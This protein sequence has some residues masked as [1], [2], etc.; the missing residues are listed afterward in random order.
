MPKTN[1]TVLFGRNAL[2]MR[3]DF[4]LTVVAGGEQPLTDADDL[5]NENTQKNYATY[6]PDYWVLDGS[7][8]FLTASANI[9]YIS[10]SQSGSDSN[11]GTDPKLKFVFNNVYSTT[12][13]VLRFA[14]GSNDYTDDITIDFYN[15]S[16]VLILSYIY[17][18][19]SWEFPT[20]QAEA[21]FKR[22]DITF[23]SSNKP[24]R[25]ARLFGIDFDTTVRW[26]GGNIKN[27][28]LTEQINPLSLELPSNEIEFT[29]F[30]DD[31]DFSITNP[32]N[33][34]AVLQENEPIEAYEQVGDVDILLGRFYLSDWESLN[35]HEARFTAKDA[36]W[37]L[38]SITYLGTWLDIASDSVTYLSDLITDGGFEHIID[39]Y[40]NGFA[41]TG[42]VPA[43]FRRNALLDAC[44]ALS[45]V[46]AFNDSVRATVSCSRSRTINISAL[47]MADALTSYDYT[48]TNSDMGN[49]KLT[50]LPV[51]T[52]AEV[53]GF[54]WRSSSD[55]TNDFTVLNEEIDAGT[56][57]IIVKDPPMYNYTVDS[58][59]AT[60][61]DSDANH[62]NLQV[63]TT[64][65]IVVT[66]RKRIMTY[67][68]VGE[69]ATGLGANVKANIVSVGQ[70]GLVGANV[71]ISEA[72]FL[73]R[74][75]QQR[76]KFTCKLY[77]STAHVGDSVLINV[78]GGQLKGYI[79]KATVNLTGGFVSDVEIIGVL[80]EV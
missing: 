21:N 13:L 75:Y 11:F 51:V 47:L 6:E 18:P 29:L 10:T 23:K 4:V 8:K 33:E 53:P 67:D 62:I 70:V 1:L 56:Y 38:G 48:L 15:A 27:G 2:T 40:W 32:A 28:T 54:H 50:L 12:G 59:D 16:D 77:A 46:S 72:K 60:I 69:D 7:Y 17:N 39:T 57:L 34:Y 36:I 25:Y 66:G 63:N 14:Q 31:P 37:M 80:V 65:T 79:E 20:N 71:A 76:Y 68:V 42:W 41:Y 58:G 45:S 35:E 49:P 61:L 78:Q 43:S 24:Y 19:D 30:S 55:S 5:N 73:L 22:I 64:G 3:T 74:Y 44:F 9:G 26:S 52:R